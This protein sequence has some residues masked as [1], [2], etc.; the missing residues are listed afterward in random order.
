MSLY[1]LNFWIQMMNISDLLFPLFLINIS[2]STFAI[3][4]VY[5]I[6]FIGKIRSHIPLSHPYLQ[7]LKCLTSTRMITREAWQETYH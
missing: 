6:D 5:V 7:T 3:L 4:N 1:I 2:N